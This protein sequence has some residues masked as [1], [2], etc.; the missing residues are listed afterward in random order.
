MDQPRLSEVSDVSRCSAKTRAGAPCQSPPFPKGM[1]RRTYER[2]CERAFEAE[3]RA[4]EGFAVR[5][6][7]LLARVE[8]GKRK[9]NF[10]S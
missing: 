3:S 6:Q 4:D 8:K 5:A 10:W 7:R 9:G 2:L 1:W